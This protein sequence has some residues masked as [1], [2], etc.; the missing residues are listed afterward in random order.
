MG[1]ELKIAYEGGDAERAA[2]HFVDNSASAVDY[3]RVEDACAAVKNEEMDFAVLPIESSTLGSIHA[4]YDLL[5]KYA[6]TSWASMTS[7]SLPHR[8]KRRTPLPTRGSCCCPRRR[9][10]RWTKD[11]RC[12]LHDVTRVRLQG[13]HSQGHAHPRAHG[14]LAARP[15]PDQDRE[16]SLGW[17]GPTAERREGCGH[18]QVQVPLL[19]PPYGRQPGGGHAQAQRDLRVRARTGLYATSQSEEAMTAVELSRKTGRVET[20]TNITM[21]DKY[22]LNPMFQKVTVAKTVLIHGQTKQ[23]E[24]EGKQVWS[25]CVGEP[26]YNPHERVL[27]AGAKAMIEGNIKYAHMKGLVELRDLISTYL[28][29]AKGLEYDPA[30]E[31]LVSNGAQQS[32]YQALYTVL[33]SR[34]EGHHPDALL[35]QLPGDRQARVRGAHSAA[36]D[37]RGELSDQPGGAGEDVDGAPGRQG[38]HPVQ[39]Q[40]PVGH[41]VVVSDEIYEQLLYQDEGVP[42]RRHVSF[43]TLPGMY[44]RTL[45][46][47]G[48]SKAHAMTGLRVG[49]LAAPKYYIDPCTLLQAQLTSCPNTVGQVAAVEALKYEL[50]CMEKGE[51]R[52]TEVMKNLDTKRRYIVKRLTAMP[53][54]RFAYPTSAFYVFLD[55][56][57]YFKVKKLLLLTRAWHLR[58]STTSVRTC[59]RIR[60][61]LWCLDRSSVTSLACAFRTRARWRRSRTQWMHGEPAE[62]SGL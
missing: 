45:L 56:S 3:K 34:S 18:P 8:S 39:P 48:F 54:V 33:S 22:P 60:T 27:A 42:E 35:A 30:T 4:N 36:H 55:L 50:E 44:E 28:E 62:I 17:P 25:L 2:R 49:F 19:R 52:I 12:G 20:G 38:Y 7:K 15:R 13:Q 37:A 10:W 11:R 14:L 16:S 43:A 9:T 51:R 47:N 59:C 5:L 61:S 58:V 46:V 41:V 32:V 23:M 29:K 24:A 6:C 21:A 26:D 1:A 31:V 53:D 57:S 40:Q